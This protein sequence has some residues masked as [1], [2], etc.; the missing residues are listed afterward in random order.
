MAEI[1]IADET[2]TV[3]LRGWE[4]VWALRRRVAVPLAR[5]RGARLDPVAAGRPKGFRWP[6]SR[7]PGVITAGTFVRKGGRDFW[8]V[9]DPTKA[10][11]I[12]LAGKPYA[13]LI[14]QVADPQATVAAIEAA[15]R[16]A[17]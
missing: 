11:V 16:R 1:E 4:V 2:L 6:G 8:S 15:R 14:V 5:V 3:R 12:A 10:V 7:L 13:R 9:R 17:R